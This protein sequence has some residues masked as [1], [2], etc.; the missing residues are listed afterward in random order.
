MIPQGLFPSQTPN[1]IVLATRNTGEQINVTTT[2]SAA[3][4]GIANSNGTFTTNGVFT[5]AGRPT[6][7]NGRV[8]IAQFPGPGLSDTSTFADSRNQFVQ[9]GVEQDLDGAFFVG[10]FTLNPANVFP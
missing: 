5:N 8:Q 7:M 10:G 9:F 2:G 6:A 1:P 4:A 3:T